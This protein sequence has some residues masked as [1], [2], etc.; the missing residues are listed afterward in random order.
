MAYTTNSSLC[1]SKERQKKNVYKFSY[2]KRP[3]WYKNRVDKTLLQDKVN[4]PKALSRKLLLAIKESTKS[5][6]KLYT[7]S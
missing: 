6:D 7:L 5:E 2:V 4:V 1:L 3:Y